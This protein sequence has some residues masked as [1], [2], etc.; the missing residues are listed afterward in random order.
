MS[1]AFGTLTDIFSPAKMLFNTFKKP[2]E[3]KPDVPQPAVNPD[4][5]QA[6]RDSMK[7]RD[8]IYARTL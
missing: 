3:D 7:R 6:A 5:M 4:A 8:S 1:K 2:D